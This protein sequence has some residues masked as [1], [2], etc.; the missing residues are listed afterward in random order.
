VLLLLLERKFGP[1]SETLC[2]KIEAADSDTLLLWAERVLTAK[3]IEE[4]FQS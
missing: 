1:L 4:V 3:D 2:Q